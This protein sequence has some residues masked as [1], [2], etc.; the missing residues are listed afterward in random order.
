VADRAV[1]N[2]R[3]RPDSNVVHVTANHRARPYARIL[4][5][6]YVSNDDRR[7]IDVSRLSDLRP[8]PFVRSNVRLPSQLSPYSS[9][10]HRR[11]HLPRRA[12]AL[13][14]SRQRYLFVVAQFI[15]PSGRDCLN[16][17]TSR[18]HP[19][20]PTDKEARLPF[21]IWSAAALLPLFRLLLP[22]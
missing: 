16:R 5:N 2:I 19:P 11:A 1:L 22:N 4:A 9:G 14:R 20:C 3:P 21:L 18:Y 12:A 6:H 17:I 8:L 10:K 13:A 7:G 15:A